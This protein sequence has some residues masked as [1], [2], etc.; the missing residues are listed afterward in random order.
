[1][2][3]QGT[4]LLSASAK[5]FGQEG[6]DFASSERDLE[7]MKEQSATTEVARRADVNVVHLG[8]A[9]SVASGACHG[10]GVNEMMSVVAVRAAKRSTARAKRR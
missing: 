6:S 5:E 2:D 10:C 4:V 3:A 8:N 9:R 7:R 1:M